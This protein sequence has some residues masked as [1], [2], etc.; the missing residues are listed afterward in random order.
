MKK[1]QSGF[2]LVELVVVIAILGILAGIAIPRF[3]I[4]NATARGS[5]IIADLNTCESAINI[6]YAKNSSFP[7]SKDEVL[8]SFLSSWP[9]APIGKAIITN[10]KGNELELEV[11]T[12][13]YVYDNSSTGSELNTKIG[14]VT[15]GGK[16]LTDL[17]SSSETSLTLVDK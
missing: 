15:L 3:L 1:P 9:N 4:A 16:T 5:K 10:N 8:G 13:K 14:R 2:T 11:Q 12:E 17:L 6:Y 7:E